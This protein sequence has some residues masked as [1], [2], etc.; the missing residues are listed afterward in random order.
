MQKFFLGKQQIFEQ[1]GKRI[2]IYIIGGSIPEKMEILSTIHL[3]YLGKMEI[4]W[5]D[6]VDP[7]FDIDVEGGIRFKESDTLTRRKYNS[8]RHGILQNKVAI[9]YDMRF[10]ELMRLM[11][12][13]S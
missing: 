5:A 1:F 2:K 4:C 12:Y 3:I 11:A 9:C 6:T 13:R 10:P 8:G 7:L